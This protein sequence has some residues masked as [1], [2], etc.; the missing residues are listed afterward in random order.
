MWL[1]RRNR[2]KRPVAIAQPDQ[3][4][5]PGGHL[6]IV[7]G[8]LSPV[9]KSK[10]PLPPWRPQARPTFIYQLPRK[11]RKNHRLLCSPPGRGSDPPASRRLVSTPGS[12]AGTCGF[13]YG[14]P[15]PSQNRKI[16]TYFATGFSQVIASIGVPI[17]VLR[18]RLP[19]V[20]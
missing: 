19:A 17:S 2:F 14:S 4:T 3:A 20:A 8:D 1:V 10:L 11:N 5:G 13:E 9:W 7:I 12:F 18:P 6:R 16:T 15:H